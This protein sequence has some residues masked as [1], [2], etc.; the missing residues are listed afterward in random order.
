MLYSQNI[1]KNYLN[2][3]G[4]KIMKI[5]LKK[6][7]QY[8]RTYWSCAYTFIGTGTHLLIWHYVVKNLAQRTMILDKSHLPTPH[9]S[10]QYSCA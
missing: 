7:E 10:S 3:L 6:I 8:T 9:T 1:R 2:V 5:I 4:D